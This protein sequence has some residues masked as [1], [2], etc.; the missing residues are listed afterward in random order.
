MYIL[1]MLNSLISRFQWNG[2]VYLLST[3]DIIH[4]TKYPLYYVWQKLVEGS[5]WTR[6]TNLYLPIP[7]LNL[8]KCTVRYC[9]LQL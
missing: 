5:L 2:H 3:L 4:M 8:G 9:L 1:Q 6:L 7:I